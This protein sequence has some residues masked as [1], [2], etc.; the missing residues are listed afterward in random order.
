[1]AA[2]AI[3]KSVAVCCIAETGINE[4]FCMIRF[5]PFVIDGNVAFAAVLGVCELVA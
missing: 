1:M 4:R 5:G 3:F 2:N